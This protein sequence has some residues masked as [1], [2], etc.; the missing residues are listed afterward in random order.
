MQA[1]G[2][3]ARIWKHCRRLAETTKA[4]EVIRTAIG[5]RRLRLAVPMKSADMRSEK[6]RKGTYDF[7]SI[8]GAR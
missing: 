7:C 3:E 6:D 4:V 5:R 2:A 8:R 1:A